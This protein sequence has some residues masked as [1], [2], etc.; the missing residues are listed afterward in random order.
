MDPFIAANLS[1][2]G[3][4][5]W[6]VLS[7]ALGMKWD[8]LLHW[9]GVGLLI[10][11]VLLA[12]KGISDVRRQWTQQPGIWKSAVVRAER[13]GSKCA[14]LF[15]LGWN[16]LVEKL[17]AV[18]RSLRWRVHQ[19]PKLSSDV[20]VGASLAT[21][22]ITAASG[23]V[24]TTGGTAEERIER[25]EKRL[26]ALEDEHYAFRAQYDKDFRVRQAEL[27]RERAERT[28]EDERLNKRLQE[29]LAD[30]VGG[31]LHLQTWGVVCLLAGTIL[32]AIW[33]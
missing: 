17:P 11:G 20:S 13:A 19:T 31:G 12:A 4:F 6:V 7:V 30:A 2:L 32:T 27:E 24:R 18:A 8:R 10:V 15:W 26:A 14:E 3:V 28:A 22:V 16:R 21:G 5:I 25:L 1:V 9:S 23:R 33:P 29:K